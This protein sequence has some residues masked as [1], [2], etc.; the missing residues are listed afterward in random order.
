[1]KLWVYTVRRLILLVPTVIGLTLLVFALMHVGGNS[2]FIAAYINPHVTGTARQLL[3]QQLTAKFHLNDPIVVQYGYWLSAV[4]H[5]D[6]GT[7]S[8]TEFQGVA[9]TT[10]LV[11]Y[12][13]NTILLTLTASLLTWIVSVPI[14]VYSAARRDSPL[15]Q[16]VRVA[17]FTLYSMPT[18]LVGFAVLLVFGPG[19]NWLPWHGN[20]DDTLYQTITGPWF[21][22][23]YAVSSP[24]HILALDALFAGAWNVAGNAWLHVVL[25]ALALTLTLFAGIIRILRASMLEVLDQDYIRLARAKGVP[26]RSVNNFHAKKNALLPTVTT[27]GYLVSG[28]LGGAV[29]IEDIFTFKGIGWLTTYAFLNQDVG[30]VMGSTL[31]F[32]LVLVATSLIL[33]LLYAFLDPRIRYE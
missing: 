29:V 32:G 3:V 4:F 15:D 11:W 9:V 1:V 5:G 33:D 25:P 6:W 8:S 23:N 19:L 20:L 27:F 14:G 13:P 18:F 24:T 2:L 30:V 16:G 28:L 31:I 22:H 21:D 7:A 12:L 26:D 17:T 10:L